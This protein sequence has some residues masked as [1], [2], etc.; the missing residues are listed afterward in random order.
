[1]YG[2]QALLYPDQ[3]TARDDR[4]VG[5]E[6]NHGI[7][8]LWLFSIKGSDELTRSDITYGSVH[9]PCWERWHQVSKLE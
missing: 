2:S 3:S 6:T 9:S 4:E 7:V 5:L 1:M 8:Y